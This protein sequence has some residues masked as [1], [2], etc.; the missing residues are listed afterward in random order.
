MTYQQNY[1]AGGQGNY[2]PRTPRPMID[3]SA[4]NLKCASCQAPITQLPFQ[5]DASRPVYCKD[6]NRNRAGRFN[7]RR[8]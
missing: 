8:S 7:D 4:M 5:P 2:P 6:C 1:Q 3:V